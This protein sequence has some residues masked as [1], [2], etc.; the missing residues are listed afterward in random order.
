MSFIVVFYQFRI[1]KKCRADRFRA[2]NIFFMVIDL[3]RRLIYNIILSSLHTGFPWP[4][5]IRYSRTDYDNINKQIKRD[6]Y[7]VNVIK[8]REKQK[9]TLRGQ[10]VKEVPC[11]FVLKK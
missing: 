6:T 2:G 8:I 4:V 5:T 11:P 9:I 1:N 10:G 3:K 7:N